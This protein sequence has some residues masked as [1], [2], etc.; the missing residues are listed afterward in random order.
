MPFIQSGTIALGH[1]GTWNPCLPPQRYLYSCHNEYSMTELILVVDLLRCMLH[2]RKTTRG[3]MSSKFVS[4][5]L[6]FVRLSLS[7][8][9]RYHTKMN[10]EVLFAYLQKHAS[11]AEWG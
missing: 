8:F 2:R 9:R 11:F 4:P 6:R 7:W 1:R 10:E 5:C 3:S